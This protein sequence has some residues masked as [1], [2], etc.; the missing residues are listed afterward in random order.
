LSGDALR[1]FSGAA[2]SVFAALLVHG[3]QRLDRVGQRRLQPIGGEH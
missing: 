1:V 3:V 2:G